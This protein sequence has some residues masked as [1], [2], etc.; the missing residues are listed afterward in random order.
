MHTCRLSG[1]P[2]LQNSGSDV[3]LFPHSFHDG[4]TQCNQC[5]SSQPKQVPRGLLALVFLASQVIFLFCATLGNAEKIS[6]GSLCE[7]LKLEVATNNIHSASLLVKQS[8]SS[9]ETILRRCPCHHIFRTCML[10]VVCDIQR[11]FSQIN[12][13]V[14][15]DVVHFPCSKLRGVQLLWPPGS[16]K[17]SNTRSRNLKVA[18]LFHVSLISSCGHGDGISECMKWIKQ[19]RTKLKSNEKSAVS[20][21]PKQSN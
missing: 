5:C 15:S 13:E 11:F 21:D 1:Q 6:G 20:R 9:P 4:R 3:S 12:L 18:R 14:T 7:T 2:H 16:Q 17:G 8:C 19:Q 10:H